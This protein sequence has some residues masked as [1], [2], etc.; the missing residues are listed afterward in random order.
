MKL[1]NEFV[2]GMTLRGWMMFTPG[3][4]IFR[5]T[6]ACL[7]SIKS[8]SN[9]AFRAGAL[10]SAWWCRTLDEAR[11]LGFK[12]AF[13]SSTIRITTISTY[14]SATPI[15]SQQSSSAPYALHIT[16]SLLSRLVNIMVG[17]AKKRQ[18]RDENQ[19]GQLPQ[20]KFYRQRAHANPFSDHDLS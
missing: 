20:K 1:L 10:K 7:C 2:R 14:V 11:C 4:E 13:L 18:K 8:M 12:F 16:W 3:S 9:P 19:D 17:P 15:T 6:N 5:M